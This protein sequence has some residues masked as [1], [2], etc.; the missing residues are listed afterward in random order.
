[1][2]EIDQMRGSV[3][4]NETVC[5]NEI[6]NERVSETMKTWMRVSESVCSV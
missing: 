4:V 6:M 1:M 2:I 3:C 5:L